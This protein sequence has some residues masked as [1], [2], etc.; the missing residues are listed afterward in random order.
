MNRLKLSPSLRKITQNISW[1]FAERVIVLAISL[2]IG[3]WV[4]RYLG[5]EKY[6]LYNYILSFMML[7]QPLAQLG[8]QPIIIRESVQRKENKSSQGIL[9][10]TSLV[11]KG[12]GSSLTLI[13][14]LIAI[15]I[16]EPNQSLAQVLIGI[17]ALVGMVQSFEVIDYWFQSQVQS[18]YTVVCRLIA[19]LLSSLLKIW[20]I[21]L[22]LSLVAFAGVMLIESIILSIGL[23]ISYQFSG[24]SFR[25][26]QFRWEQVGLLLRES[27]PQMLASFSI[28]IQARIDQVMLGQMINTYE[29]GQYSVAMRMIEIFNFIP[30]IIVQSL[31]PSVTEAKSISNELYLHRLE[32]IYRLM[33][34][35]FLIL[36]LPIFCFAKP[37][38]ILLFGSKYT[39]AGSLMSLFFIRLFFASFG[40]TRYLYIVNESL[41]RYSLITAIAGSVINI[42]FNYLWIPNYASYGALWATILSFTITIFVLDF[43]APP[44]KINLKLMM[45]AILFPGKFKIS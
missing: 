38:I 25:Y 6:G 33:W 29:V 12:I 4:A 14:S 15:T 5:P 18:K 39:L 13:L 34:L 42:F 40:V 2:G 3:V 36:A 7:F 21:Q 30:V 31:S 35:S 43:F 27:W 1:L 32:N 19:F 10:G 37:A 8:L 11:L 41:F 26:W 9:L 23:I 17:F 45:R 22:Q 24:E 28:L 44:M 16:L 20:V